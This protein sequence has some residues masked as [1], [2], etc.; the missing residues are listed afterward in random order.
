M[1]TQTNRL[2]DKKVQCLSQ[3]PK[4]R[5]FVQKRSNPHWSGRLF[6]RRGKMRE[7]QNLRNRKISCWR[8]HD[9]KI[10]ANKK[11]DYRLKSDND[12]FVLESR[13]RMIIFGE[14]E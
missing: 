3:V 9:G 8:L 6:Y 7:M 12:S 10:F 14:K 1:F 5:K 13:A 2:S 4:M 11:I